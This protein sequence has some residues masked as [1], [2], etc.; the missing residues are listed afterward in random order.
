MMVIGLAL[1]L[2]GLKSAGVTAQELSSPQVRTYQG[3]PYLSG[4]IG[5]EE[6]DTLRRLARDYN[7]QLIFAAKEGYYVSDVHVTIADERGSK[8]L[9]AVSEGPWF[10]TKL[11]SGKYTIRAQVNGQT[12]QRVAQVGQQKQTQLQFYW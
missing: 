12:Q 1:L 7:V 10:Y 5:E 8:V 6:R 4:G 2:L 9:E 3:I 11:P